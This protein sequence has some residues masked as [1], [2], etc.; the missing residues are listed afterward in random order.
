M[1]PT[2]ALG[3]PIQPERDGAKHRW[4]VILSVPYETYHWNGKRGTPAVGRAYRMLGGT[5][6]KDRYAADE[7]ARRTLRQVVLALGQ[8]DTDY[9]D[10]YYG[11]P[12]WKREADG[13][14]PSTRSPPARG[15][16]R[17]GR[18]TRSRQRRD[19]PAAAPVP[20]KAALRAEARVR[21]LKGERL[22]FDEESKALYDAVAPTHPPNRTSSRSSTR[23][24]SASRRRARS[25]RGTTRGAARS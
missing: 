8:H 9:V 11:P 4:V 3:K 20:R 5:T 25:S 24:R 2:P 7:W 6:G 22:S 19:E 12:E 10:A 17:R 15:A 16:A 13:R 18:A 14:R 21:M 1:R 23:S